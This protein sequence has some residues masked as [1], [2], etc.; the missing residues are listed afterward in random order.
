MEESS[1]HRALSSIKSDKKRRPLTDGRACQPLETMDFLNV[2]AD[3]ESARDLVI[4]F[5]T[6]DTEIT[7]AAAMGLPPG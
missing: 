1:E 3:F 6:E 2:A 7:E 4:F 5:T